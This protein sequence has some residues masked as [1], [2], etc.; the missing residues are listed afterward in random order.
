MPAGCELCLP[1]SP[2]PKSS[3][4]SHGDRKLRPVVNFALTTELCFKYR[5]WCASCVPWSTPHTWWKP[6][7]KFHVYRDLHLTHGGSHVA[8]VSLMQ[9]NMYNLFQIKQTVQFMQHIICLYSFWF[10]D[11]WQRK[12]LEWFRFSER[13]KCRKCSCSLWTEEKMGNEVHGSAI[14]LL[15]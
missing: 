7:S 10:T 13:R 15:K 3:V 12:M 5:Y 6:C 8:T 14:E 9:Q 11:S 1:V 4:C 2:S